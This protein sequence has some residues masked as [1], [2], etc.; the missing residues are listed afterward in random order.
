LLSCSE[1]RAGP[2]SGRFHVRPH[3]SAAL[4]SRLIS[5]VLAR[6]LTALDG[7]QLNN[8]DLVALA[9]AVDQASF[10]AEVTEVRHKPPSV[11]PVKDRSPTSGSQKSRCRDV[12]A[13]QRKR[14]SGTI[15]DGEVLCCDRL[16]TWKIGFSAQHFSIDDI[17]IRG[18]TPRRRR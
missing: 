5:S 7:D 8:T 4:L 18:G 12:K 2:A 6:L 15:A 17:S 11:Q 13:G 9:L 14:E 16:P 10:T 1:K 3:L